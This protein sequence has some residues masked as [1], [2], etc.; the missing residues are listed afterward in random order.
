MKQTPLVI[1]AVCVIVAATSLGIFYYSTTPS[2][3]DAPISE[4]VVAPEPE[5]QEAAADQGSGAAA[6]ETTAAE[7]AEASA[8]AGE[9]DTQTDAQA[10][11]EAKPQAGTQAD[12]QSETQPEATAEAEV[13]RGINLARVRPDGTAVIAGIATPGSTVTLMIGD[14]VIGTA[15]VTANGEWVVVPDDILPPG[16]YLVT[17]TVTTPDGE[18]NVEAMA[19][20]I[21]IM[22]GG[23][24]TPLVAL[25]PYAVEDAPVT[26]LQ[27]PDA[28]VADTAEAGAAAATETSAPMAMMPLVTIRSIQAFN[29]G[30]I[31]VGGRAEGGMRVTL[32][33]NGKSTPPQKLNG[34]GSYQLGQYI[35]TSAEKVKL[36]VTL[37]DDAGAG[38]ASAR[39]TLNRGQL[40]TTLASNTLVVVQKGDALWRIAY[41]TYGKGIRYVDIYRENSTIIRD[42]DLIYPDQIFVVPNS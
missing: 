8:S 34:T 5:Q 19:L 2:Q 16:S 6:P 31:S 42:P 12:T 7:T 40:D 22:P 27:A 38:L 39:L 21:E 28:T 9:T 11:P 26:V 20:V 24:E 3:T 29:P 14:R 17:A 1:I 10:Q 35:D 33:A 30:Y 25:V 15:E 37:T 4:P 41:Q 23:D 32:E 36:K 18:T 13:T